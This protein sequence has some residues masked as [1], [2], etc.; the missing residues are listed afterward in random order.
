MDPKVT[1]LRMVAVFSAFAAVWHYPQARSFALFFAGHTALAFFNPAGRVLQ[2]EEPP[3]DP[4]PPDDKNGYMGEN[5]A[6]SAT[7]VPPMRGKPT[8]FSR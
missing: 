5:T 2:S 6:I 4:R 7:T 3:S 8:P 1:E